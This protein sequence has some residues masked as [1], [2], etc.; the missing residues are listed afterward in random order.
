MQRLGNW[1]TDP[2]PY[3]YAYEMV[4]PGL[5]EVDVDMPRR[6]LQLQGL[7]IGARNEDELE[8]QLYLR[9]QLI[10]ARLCVPPRAAWN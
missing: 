1:S 2:W 3:E 4:R 8:Q 5:W 7:M 10:L 9:L 6:H